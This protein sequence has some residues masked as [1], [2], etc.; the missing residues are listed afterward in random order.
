[1]SIESMAFSK[2][3]VKRRAFFGIIAVSALLTL[4]TGY[5]AFEQSAYAT[6][7][8]LVCNSGGYVCDDHSGTES[9]PYADTHFNTLTGPAAASHTLACVGKPGAQTPHNVIVC[10]PLH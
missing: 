7:P 2:K 6:T 5:F 4:M 1:M 9:Q 3:K 10:R 8:G